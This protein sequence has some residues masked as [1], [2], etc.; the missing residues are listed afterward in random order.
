MAMMR[1]ITN[2]VL[3]FLLLLP[4]MSMAEQADVPKFRDYPAA[5]V[6]KGK[7]ANVVLATAEEKAFRTRLREASKQAVNFAG[8]YVLST[9]GCGTDCQYGAAVSLK[10]GHVVFLPGTICCWEGEGDRLEF[11][12]NSRLLVAAGMINEKGKYGAHFYEFTGRGFK[13][14]KTVA[15][16]NPH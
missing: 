7:H 5:N 3:I 15:V 4:V 10:T 11:R 2:S 8:E 9:W 6:Y 12:T 14:L 13:P 1:H 16:A